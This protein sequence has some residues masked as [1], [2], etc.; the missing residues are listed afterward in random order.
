MSNHAFILDA[1]RFD[2][3]EPQHLTDTSYFQPDCWYHCQRDTHGLTEWLSH[4]GMAESLIELLLDGA[5]RP[6]FQMLDNKNFLLILR[7]VNLN[8]G[9]DPDDMLSLRIIY[10]NNS[11][12][13]LRRKSFKGIQYIQHALEQ[14]TDM[15]LSIAELIVM[16][17]EQINSKIELIIDETEHNIDILELNIDS[18]SHKEKR[19]LTLLQRRLL[20]LFR[21]LK[22]QAIALQSLHSLLP[23]LLASQAQRIINEKEIAIR[24]NEN[25]ESNVQIV[26]ALHDDLH[27][28]A[29]EK[30]GRNSY[31]L[32]LTA[33]VF[34]PISFIT[35]LF[36]ANVAG[37]PGSSYPHA[38]LWFCL[39]LSITALAVFLTL[40]RFR[41]W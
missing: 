14:K 17:I 25:I 15:P 39:G 9:D 18:L 3:D 12:I 10:Y 4:I 32:S 37:I 35:S 34:L 36:G 41:F 8:A 11:V 6:H 5:S 7:G 30:M 33:G 27:Q 26:R 38:F 22:P 40:R 2:E 31:Y 28:T 19:Q 20:R 21:Y 16:L 13:T 23:P 29:A 24:I 1:W